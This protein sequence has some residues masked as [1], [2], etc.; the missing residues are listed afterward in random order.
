MSRICWTPVSQHNM[1]GEP[2]YYATLHGAVRDTRAD[3]RAMRLYVTYDDDNGGWG[4]VGYDKPIAAARG[5]GRV[6][7]GGMERR[8]CGARRD[9]GLR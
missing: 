2:M 7:R 9:Q 6:T 4:L 5:R 3:H 8:R 1:L